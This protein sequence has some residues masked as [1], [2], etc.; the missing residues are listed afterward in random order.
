MGSEMCI[1]DR[2]QEK[3]KGNRR[4]SAIRTSAYLGPYRSPSHFLSFF[5]PFPP[6][7]L[8]PHARPDPYEQPSQLSRPNEAHP[9]VSSLSLNHSHALHVPTFSSPSAS[10][11]PRRRPKPL[12]FLSLR[13]L[14]CHGLFFFPPTIIFNS[15]DHNHYVL[16][17]ITIIKPHQLGRE[18]RRHSGEHQMGVRELRKRHVVFCFLIHDFDFIF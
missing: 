4:S 2:D 5:S 9:A 12:F 11:L 16:T 3:K 8:H 13:P 18:R 1:R 10:S 7:S 14:S 6:S 15:S 17:P